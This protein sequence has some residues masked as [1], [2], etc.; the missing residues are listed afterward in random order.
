MK[1]SMI[2]ALS[3]IL[4]FVSATFVFKIQANSLSKNETMNS[5][6]SESINK[7]SRILEGKTIVIDAGHGGKDVGA[8]GQTGTYEKDITLQTAL[9]I[10][11][12]LVAKTGVNV[13]L[14]RDK[15]EFLTLDERV[16]IAKNDSADLFISIHFDSFTS[17]DVAGITTYYNKW[18][19]HELANILHK[20]LFKLNMD[21]KDRGVEKGDFHVLRENA[22]PSLLLELGYISNKE[23]EQRIQSQ[24][25]QTNVANAVTDGII[26]VLNKQISVA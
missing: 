6:K 13:V 17:D 11:R 23:D 9:N 12:E 4:L 7:E 14:T 20:Q 24:A 18:E 1:K 10:E 22:S 19:D 3:A 21:T 5:I 25:F 26:A 16:D 8:T 15:D 2:L